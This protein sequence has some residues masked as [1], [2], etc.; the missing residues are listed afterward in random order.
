MIASHS[1]TLLSDGAVDLDYFITR[2]GGLYS[3][4]GWA[5]KKGAETAYTGSSDLRFIHH[6]N[7]IFGDAGLADD[8]VGIN[9]CIVASKKYSKIMAFRVK[10][11]DTVEIA[12][13]T[14]DSQNTTWT[15]GSIDLSST[16]TYRG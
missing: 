15:S 11:T 16:G 12:S 4:T 5:W 7:D 9:N 2:A 10:G 6:H 3:N 13:R 8:T 14:F 1:G